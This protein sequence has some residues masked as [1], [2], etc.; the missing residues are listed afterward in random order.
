[1]Y[2]LQTASRIGTNSV[3]KLRESKLKSGLP[4]MINIK[5]L[6]TN[7]CYLEYPDGSIKL[8]A[9][10]HATVNMNVV[11]ELTATEADQLRLRLHFQPINNA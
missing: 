1:M 3:K 11:R 2:T 6:P 9:V 7:Q 8:M 10:V 5:E 4:F